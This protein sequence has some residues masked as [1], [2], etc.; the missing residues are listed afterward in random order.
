MDESSTQRHLE[1]AEKHELAA[2]HHEE[3]A[4]HWA[5]QGDL[6]RA[7]LQRK[8][9]AHERHGADLERRWAALD[10]RGEAPDT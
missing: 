10:Q 6:E 8:I 3:S 4:L 5:Q 2:R 1:A 9:A 7:D